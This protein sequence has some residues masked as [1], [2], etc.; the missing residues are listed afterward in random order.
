MT[1]NPLYPCGKRCSRGT[2]NGFESQSRGSVF[3]SSSIESKI[4]SHLDL[5]SS[6]SQISQSDWYCRNR[7]VLCLN[8]ARFFRE[9]L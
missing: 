1:M 8:R 7:E 2:H 6:N 5:N 3:N 4:L 9:I